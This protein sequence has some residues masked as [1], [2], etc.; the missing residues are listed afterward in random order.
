M[1]TTNPLRQELQTYRNSKSADLKLDGGFFYRRAV[2]NKS[3]SY[4]GTYT[5]LYDNADDEHTI[6]GGM[7]PR[8]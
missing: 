5:D 7:S 3:A 6:K 4:H 8:Y 2:P 1:A